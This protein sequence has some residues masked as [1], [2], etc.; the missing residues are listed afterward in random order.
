VPYWLV[1]KK[2]KSLR[3]TPFIYLINEREK[4]SEKKKKG[5]EKRKKEKREDSNSISGG[6]EKEEGGEKGGLLHTEKGQKGKRL[7]EL[8]PS[9]D[10]EGAISFSSFQ[11]KPRR[12][13]GGTIK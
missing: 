8:F 1:S 10:E 9:V 11:P 4:G 5:G 7:R 3:Y 6:Q 12:R 13:I 2:R